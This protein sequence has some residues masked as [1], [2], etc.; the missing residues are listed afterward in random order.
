M[1]FIKAYDGVCEYKRKE[2]IFKHKIQST[3]LIELANKEVYGSAFAKKV[4]LREAEEERKRHFEENAG[5]V[6]QEYLT[7]TA[8]Y[9]GVYESTILG[10][11]RNR[12]HVLTRRCLILL[13]VDLKLF[14]YVDIA[15]FMKKHHSTIMHAENEARIDLQ[16]LPIFENAYNNLKG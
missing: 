11:D 14:T 8:L 1:E 2:H 3:D 16:S 5:R 4:L 9:F 12:Y 15:I 13:L 10:S 6:M 7:K